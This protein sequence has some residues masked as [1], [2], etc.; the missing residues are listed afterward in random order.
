MDIALKKFDSHPSILQ[1]RKYVSNT[2]FSFNA[3]SQADVE[4]VIKNINPK[5]VGIHNDIPVKDFKQ[6]YDICCPIL[7]CIISDAILQSTFPDKLKLAD[8]APLSKNDDVTNK[9]NYRPISMLHCIKSV[10]KANPKPNW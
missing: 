1:I 4:T 5:K 10:R 8:I 2:T 7:L 9:A 3:V 6:N